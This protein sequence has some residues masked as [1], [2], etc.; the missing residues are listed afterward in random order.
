M[1]I[2][3]HLENTKVFIRP[4]SGTAIYELD[5]LSSGATF[6]QTF[7]ENTYGEKTLQNSGHLVKKG[8]FI[9][10]NPANFSF[11]A[12]DLCSS[13]QSKVSCIKYTSTS[14]LRNHVMILSH[15]PCMPN[16]L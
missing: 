5:L 9:K 10:A 13:A 12:K 16:T 1:D 3:H 14:W 7:T 2:Y 15:L 4:T 11:A 6:S 8:N